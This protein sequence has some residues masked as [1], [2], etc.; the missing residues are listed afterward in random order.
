MAFNIFRTIFL[1]TRN[2]VSYGYLKRQ[3]LLQNQS[4]DMTSWPSEG[5]HLWKPFGYHGNRGSRVSGPLAQWIQPRLLRFVSLQTLWRSFYLTAINHNSNVGLYK[6]RVI[7]I[8]CQFNVVKI[9]LQLK[10]N[11]LIFMFGMHS[12]VSGHEF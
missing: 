11:K 6:I 7:L 9:F 3:N 10:E 2:S 4:D 8:T 12:F 5:M 1:I